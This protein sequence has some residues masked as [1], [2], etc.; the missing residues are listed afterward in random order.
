MSLCSV[1][2]EAGFAWKQQHLLQITVPII[3]FRINHIAITEY[4]NDENIKVNGYFCIFDFSALP[5]DTVSS[6]F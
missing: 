1:E 3:H 6:Q 2:R 5:P 4:Y